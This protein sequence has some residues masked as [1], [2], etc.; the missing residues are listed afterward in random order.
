M[1]CDNGACDIASL[2]AAVDV[3]AGSNTLDVDLER[4]FL[5]SGTVTDASSDPIKDAV[6]QVFDAFGGPAVGGVSSTDQNGIWSQPVVD[7]GNYY[8]HV[9]ESGRTEYVHEVWN[10][11]PCDGCDPVATGDAIVV[12]AGDVPNIDFQLDYGGG[13]LNGVIVD[14]DDGVTP[15]FPVRIDLV[16]SL[17][18]E[19][20]GFAAENSADGSYSLQ[21][22]PPGDYKVFFNA[23]FEAETW[24]DELHDDVPCPDALCDRALLGTSINIMAGEN[25]LDASLSRLSISGTVLD[26]NSQPLQNVAVDVLDENG[27]LVAPGAAFTDGNG[28]WLKYLPGPGIYYVRT[29]G[30]WTPSHQPE[31]WLNTPCDACN[32]L[33]WGTPIEV[34]TDDI[35]GIDFQLDPRPQVQF[36]GTVVDAQDGITPVH[37][38][39]VDLLDPVTGAT[40]GLVAETDETGRFTF[41]DI[42]VGPYKI[43]FNAHDAAD[44]Y[45]DE[46]YNNIECIDFGCDASAQG[47]VVH[48]LPGYSEV[49]VDLYTPT[50]VNGTILDEIDG[51]TPI[52]SVVVSLHD[53]VTGD[54][55]PDLWG[56]T[57]PDGTYTISNV[58]P[59]EYLVIFNALNESNDYK[60]ELYDEVPCDNGACD[61]VGEGK[62]FKVSPGQNLL[63][64]RL[65]YGITLSGRVTDELDSPMPG[66]TIEV[67]DAA[68][69]PVC[70]N[71]TTDEQGDWW[72][73]VPRDQDYF[74]R[75]A[76]IDLNGYLPEVWNDRKC[77]DCDPI[78]TGTPIV[79]NNTDIGGID[80]ELKKPKEA[81]K[82]CSSSG[83]ADIILR[84]DFEHLPERKIVFTRAASGLFTGEADEANFEVELRDEFNVSIDDSGLIWCL[85]DDTL[86]DLVVEGGSATVTA[87]GFELGS[88]DLVVRDPDSLAEARVPLIFAE[89]QSNA[90]EVDGTLV[91][92][93]ES[94]PIGKHASCA[95]TAPRSPNPFRSAMSSQPM[96]QT[97]S[98]AGLQQFR[99]FPTTSSS[100]SSQQ[101]LLTSLPVLTWR[102]RVRPC[103]S[104]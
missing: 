67:F 57:G 18:G 103:P 90:H 71:A 16:N 52:T 36:S 37:P 56:I 46:L 63:D 79:V 89:L 23:G 74:A 84:S 78:S 43:F 11:K 42:P 68:G 10:D 69:N 50:S 5:I 31:I 49:H 80:F 98:S 2:G 6:I 4:V 19:W 58:P 87:T 3:A 96:A 72:L 26:E 55:I 54:D 25:V 48:I 27:F 39:A 22:I 1:A 45:H 59:G 64:A 70:C 12:S 28:D 73:S 91:I 95:W 77:I 101:V 93:G 94:P 17:T 75:V 62:V 97:P 21:G 99:C 32:P 30:Q 60:D 34:G 8:A 47:G 7:P 14:A 35:S 51:E 66:L 53:T 33:I 38:V 29:V 88:V 65:R 61:R 86:L 24:V 85:T 40:L 44:S 13:T 92:S 102:P 76:N 104:R 9:I 81:L 15:V 82:A 83:D 100:Q 41:T 20:E